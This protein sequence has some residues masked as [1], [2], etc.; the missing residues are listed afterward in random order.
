MCVRVTC[1]RCG[2]PT[3]KGCGEHIEEALEG[4]PVADRCTCPR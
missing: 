4:V 2:Q 3:W 1:K